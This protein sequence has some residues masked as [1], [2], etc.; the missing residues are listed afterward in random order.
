MIPSEWRGTPT[1][2]SVVDRD[3]ASPWINRDGIRDS[4]PWTSGHG[5]NG[6]CGQTSD[7]YDGVKGSSTR[8][9]WVDS[10]WPE[11]EWSRVRRFEMRLQCFDGKGS[12]QTF[13]AK[14]DHFAVHNRWTETERLPYLAN[15]LEDPAAQILWNLR[16]GNSY[17]FGDMKRT[18]EAVYRKLAKLR[19]KG[20][21]L[22]SGAER[23]VRPQQMWPK[24]FVS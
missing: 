24:M 22:R 12:I 16:P 4:A 5:S 13:L 10:P 18:L 20:P 8:V 15:C 11:R 14:F 1:G 9:G 17:T 19:C 7:F 23:K 21:N 3:N 2:A 6:P